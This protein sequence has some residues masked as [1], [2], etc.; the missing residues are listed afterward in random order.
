ML[1]YWA[2]VNAVTR[3]QCN[4]TIIGLKVVFPVALATACPPLRIR[5]NMMRRSLGHV[6]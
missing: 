1:Q 4:Y 6:S 2:G 5:N 3:Q